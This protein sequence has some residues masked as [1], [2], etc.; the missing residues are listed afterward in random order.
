[1]VQWYWL[2]ET[3]P[4][5][6]QFNSIHE[7]LIARWKELT[8]YIPSRRVDFCSMDNAEDWT[9]ATYLA[10][11][12]QQAELASSI[13]MIEEMGRDGVR[14]VSPDD[15]PLT[16]VFKLYPWEWMVEEEFGKY[17][18]L[19]DAMCGWSRAGRCCCQIR[20][21]CRCCGN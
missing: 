2:E 10:D 15:Q 16:T 4:S 6:D 11:K 8:P 9:T 7:R 14:F 20:E 17:L 12:A 13:F 3:H 18:D 5:S 21:S 19:A 1:V